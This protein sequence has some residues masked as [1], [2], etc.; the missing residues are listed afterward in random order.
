M[1][2]PMVTFTQPNNIINIEKYFHSSS[3]E[4]WRLIT[5]I[6]IPEILPYYYIS[7]IGRVYSIYTNKILS[8]SISDTS[9][10]YSIAFA[11]YNGT[12]IRRTIHRMEMIM[13]NH[14]EN[15]ENLVVNHID[16]NKINNRLWNLEWCTAKENIH[17][18]IENNLV[19]RV[20]GEDC[21]NVSI[22]DE[23]AHI[24]CK[25]IEKQK[26]SHEEIANH[27]GCNIMTVSHISAGN[28][29]EQ[30]T[31]LYN[32]EKRKSLVFT[33]KEFDDI[34]EYIKNHINDGLAKYQLV[35]NVLYFVGIKYDKSMYDG[36]NYIIKR[37]Q[38]GKL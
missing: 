30:V 12:Y 36:V 8:P 33:N 24:I 35:R 20:Y 5:D 32:M 19:T 17:H 29:W 2:N 16:C 10:Y 11:T 6:A 27:I 21:S 1:I 38:A 4:E 37:V 15:F 9:Q 14:I 18:A 7:N 31:K 13:F 22:T 23:Q 26:Y 28:S 34:L 3:Y 25:M